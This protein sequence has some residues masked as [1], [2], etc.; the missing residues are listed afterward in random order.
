MTKQRPASIPRAVPYKGSWLSQ[1]SPSTGVWGTETTES[2]LPTAAR[3]A[4]SARAA[5]PSY[6]P[7]TATT[8]A[9]PG[10]SVI[11]QGAHN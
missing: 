5:L 7:I 8:L 2:F 10:P 1:E 4:G 11:P 6:P 3:A 9:K